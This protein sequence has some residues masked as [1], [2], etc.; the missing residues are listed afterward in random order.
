[1]TRAERVSKL[2]VPTASTPR[3]SGR[4]G[5]AAATGDAEAD[6]PKVIGVL[7]GAASTRSFCVAA[8]LTAAATCASVFVAPPSRLGH[9][10]GARIGG[11]CRR[12]SGRPAAGHT[13]SPPSTISAAPPEHRDQARATPR[14]AIS[15]SAACRSH[16]CAFAW[17]DVVLHGCFG[18]RRRGA[19]WWCSGRR[20]R[21]LRTRA[22]HGH[23]RREDEMPDDR[24]DRPA[25]RLEGDDGHASDHERRARG[26][27]RRVRVRRLPGG[28]NDRRS[29]SVSAIVIAIRAMALAVLLDSP[30][31]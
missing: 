16:A 25:G 29:A 1:M 8:L 30:S 23:A 4:D 26:V 24:G 21:W 27:L 20:T 19:P 31:S 18:Q 6:A 17:F 28:R 7:R 9:D 15:A 13:R 10:D 5:A 12:R 2:R 11:S 3:A 14:S 22:V